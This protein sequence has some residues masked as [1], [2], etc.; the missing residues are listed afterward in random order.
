[1]ALWEP[2]SG[3]AA[4]GASSLCLRGGVD[5][6][7]REGTAAAHGVHRPARVPAGA[8]AGSA[9]PALQAAG[10]RHR[11]R[12][13]RGLAPAP[14]AAVGVP[15]P[16]AVPARHAQT[17][18]Q[19]AV[20]SHAAQASPTSAAPCYAALGPVDRLGAEEGKCRAP[21]RDWQLAPPADLCR[22]HWVKPAGLLSMV[23][24]WRA[25]MSG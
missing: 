24:T 20:G 3:Q 16:P 22:S 9:G 13:V 11:P 19:P 21:A 4:A 18:P 17:T 7:A 25:F 8:V 6:E 23:G 10:G 5:R 2:L 12:A 15:G 14:A 1:M